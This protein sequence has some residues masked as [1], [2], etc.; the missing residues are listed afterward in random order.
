[1]YSGQVVTAENEGVEGSPAVSKRYLVLIDLYII[2]DRLENSHLRNHTMTAI[3]DLLRTTNMNSGTEAILV[4]Y[5][6]TPENSSIRRFLVDSYL[7]CK[8][9]LM[10]EWFM[11]AR[12]GLPADFVSDITF[13]LF[14]A[15][16]AEAIC[17]TER[18][19]CY[20]NSHDEETPACG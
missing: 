10:A 5:W 17:P 7:V 2:A 16:L 13:G 14:Q 11:K 6:E 1:M 15:Q 9:Q 8:S 18:P 19:E 4:V 12:H 3:V 20:Y